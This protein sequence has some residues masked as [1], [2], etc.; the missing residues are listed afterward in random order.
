MKK[1][2]NMAIAL[3]LGSLTSNAAITAGDLAIVGYNS[4]NPDRF[5]ILALDEIAA[6]ETFLYTDNGWLS[7][8]SFRSGEGTKTYTV[9]A[10]I[11]VGSI[12]EIATSEGAGTAP[13]LSTGGDQL[14]LFT[15]SVG[16]PTNIY[17]L[18]N[19][20]AGV[21]QVNATNSNTSALPVGLTNGTTAVALDEQDN[22]VFDFANNGAAKTAA[23][24]LTAIG[25]KDNWIDSSSTRLSPTVSSVTVDPVP[26][27]SSTALLGLGG[28][29][30]LMRRYR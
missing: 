14:I 25:D 28:L 7:S 18:N 15:G 19:E 20:G 21:W 23:Q 27:P 30:L 9:G 6:G 2:I 8:G 10:T 16:S 12:V 5:W 3:A 17:G 13:A 22:A 24:W 4:D 11:A 1:T 26:E 29:A